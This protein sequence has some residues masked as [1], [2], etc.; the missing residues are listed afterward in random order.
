MEYSRS[1]S[2]FSV[3]TTGSVINLITDSSFTKE[4][5]K[6]K[7]VLKDCWELEANDSGLKSWVVQIKYDSS[8][9]QWVKK[10]TVASNS[11]GIQFQFYPL[12]DS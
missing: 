12:L 4:E 8:I 7:M 9:V 3:E 10:Q 2:I 1:P 6:I 11:L 5:S